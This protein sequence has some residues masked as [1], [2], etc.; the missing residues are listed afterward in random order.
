MITNLSQDLTLSHTRSLYLS[1]EIIFIYRYNNNK[2][3][4][5]IFWGG[6]SEMALTRR[7]RCW[8]CYVRVYMRKRVWRERYRKQ[9]KTHAMVHHTQFG[10]SLSHSRSSHR[11]AFI[12]YLWVL[13]RFAYKFHNW[14]KL[15]CSSSFHYDISHMRAPFQ[16]Q[17][18]EN[19]A[20]F[21]FIS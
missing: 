15:T 8:W 14:S 7:H 20:F 18:C 2:N 21:L 3:E 17:H 12:C 4:L 9:N 11:T 10:F 1:R 6:E 5:R 16:T 19:F 13:F